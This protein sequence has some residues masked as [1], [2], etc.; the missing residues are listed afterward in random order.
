MFHSRIMNNKI[1]W[2]HERCMRLIYEDKTSSF[3]ELLE[4]ERSVLIHTGNLQILA[5]EMFKMYRSMLPPIFTES[6]RRR[7]YNLRSNS[8]FAV[9]NVKSVFHESDVFPT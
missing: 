1:N 5:T 8:I 2:L 6:F 3:E 7:D 4:Q 9:L